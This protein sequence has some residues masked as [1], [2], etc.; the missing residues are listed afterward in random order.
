MDLF[1]VSREEVC[2]ADFDVMGWCVVF[3]VVIAVVGGARGPADSE[4]A[5][6]G[7]TLDPIEPHVDCLGPLDFGAA[8][9]ESIG[10]GVIRCDSGWLCLGPADFSKDL[11]DMDCLLAIVE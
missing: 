10:R 6:V 2:G 7:A 9:G 8:V 5:L 4:L 1:A 11:A 3:G